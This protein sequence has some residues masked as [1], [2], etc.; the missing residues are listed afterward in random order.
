MNA[1]LVTWEWMGNYAA[2]ADVVASVLPPQWSADRVK[3][4][5]TLLYANATSTVGE[6]C[7]YAKKPR[8][9]PYRAEYDVIEGVP[10]GG[11][12]RC[13]HHPW[14]YARP[15]TNLSVERTEAG[16]ER[17]K[18]TEP[19]VVRFI[20]NELRMETVRKGLTIAIERRVQGALSHEGTWDHATNAFKLGFQPPAL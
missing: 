11:R 19:D 9:N 20:R 7:D 1:W 2:V 12:I 8:S 14:L 13:G 4:T 6:L 15:V 16:M 18:W 17:V 10:F 5:V 3:D